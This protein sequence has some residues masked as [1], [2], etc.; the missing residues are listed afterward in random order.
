MATTSW[1]RYLTPGPAHWRLGLVCL[2]AGLQAGQL[3][4]VRERTLDCYAAV[5]VNRGE[6]W[7]RTAVGQISLQAPALFWLFPSV[8]H[9]Y[10]PTA[11]G[12]SE[13][14]VLF[15]GSAAS[16]YEELGVL[17]RRRPVEAAS[18]A[19]ARTFERL[20]RVCARDDDPHRTVAAT[21]A[22]H[23]LLLA[24]ARARDSGGSAVLAA[25]RAEALAPRSI[26][27]HARA[28]GLSV[29]ALRAAV[30]REAGCSPK[31]FLLQVRLSEA[32]TLLAE[33]DLAVARVA[34]RVGYDDANY[35]SRLFTR[36]VGVTPSAFRDQYRR[37]HSPG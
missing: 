35:F 37:D 32:K 10:G 2:G 14:W 25:L 9:S 11:A 6:G 13:R 17:D 31:Q 20:L 4:P 3:V 8:E 19:P 28:L 7:L 22:T 21:A 29:A 18:A 1:A 26:F 5:L 23:E 12:W 30:Q 34:G 33:S 36:H 27:E 24:A 16:A 15:A